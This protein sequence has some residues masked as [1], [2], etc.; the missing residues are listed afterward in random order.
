MHELRRLSATHLSGPLGQLAVLTNLPIASS[1]QCRMTEAAT[2][3][4]ARLSR[5]FRRG[6]RTQRQE[7]LAASSPHPGVAPG[8]PLNQSLSGYSDSPLVS[9]LGFASPSEARRRLSRCWTI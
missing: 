4:H 1:D 6:I 7:C 2:R 5:A 8:Y 3:I 9:I